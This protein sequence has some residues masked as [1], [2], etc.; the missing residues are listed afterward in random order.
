VGVGLEKVTARQADQGRADGVAAEARR[1]VIIVDDEAAVRSFVGAVVRKM[2]LKGIEATSADDVKRIAAEQKDAILVLDLSLGRDDGVEILETLAVERF[3]GSVILMSG[4]ERTLLDQVHAIGTRMNLNMLPPLRKPFKPEALREVILAAGHIKTQAP[5]KVDLLRALKDNQLEVRYEP[6]V[7]LATLQPI[8]A[9]L[10]PYVK[11]AVHGLIGPDRFAAELSDAEHTALAQV[12]ARRAIKD[13][14]TMV[15]NG[16]GLR[17]SFTVPIAELLGPDLVNIIRRERPDDSRWPGL[18]LEVPESHFGPSAGAIEETVV[19]LRLHKVALAIGEFGHNP[20]SY[21]DIAALPAA[22]LRIDRRF[23]HDCATHG[24]NL[25]TC[26]AVIR[27]G[28]RLKLTVVAAG[29]DT[30][31]DLAMLKRLG[32]NAAQGKVFSPAVPIEDFQERLSR[33]R[34]LSTALGAR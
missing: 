15:K 23:V 9:E 4:H 8:G 20:T 1:A 14:H 22:E 29:V 21:G 11:H 3:T 31:A 19:R 24:K 7:D 26:Q 28:A 5:I 33:I 13:W 18:I 16:F 2:G 34:A 10:V 27:L 30:A 12:L 32:C 17:L 6:R 25:A